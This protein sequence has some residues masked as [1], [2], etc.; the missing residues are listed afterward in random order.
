[1]MLLDA[2]GGKQYGLEGAVSSYCLRRHGGGLLP[3]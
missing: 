1:M 2:G 3:L